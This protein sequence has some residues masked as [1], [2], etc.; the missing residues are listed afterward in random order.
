MEKDRIQT[1][2]DILSTYMDP[3]L[4]KLMLNDRARRDLCGVEHEAA[5]LFVDIRHF[6]TVCEKLSPTKVSQLLSLFQQYVM[7]MIHRYGGI[8]DKMMGDTTMAYWLN[9]KEEPEEDT[10]KDK[11]NQAIYDA[12]AEKA[13]KGALRAAH[14]IIREI[15]KLEKKAV[16]VCGYPL[17]VAIGIH[18]GP[19]YFGNIGSETRKD[20]TIVGNAVNIAAKLKEMAPAGKV[21]VS[22]AVMDR[23]SDEFTFATVLDSDEEWD[24]IFCR[25]GEMTIYELVQKAKELSV[26]QLTNQETE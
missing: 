23:V 7:D 18:Y 11:I 12:K 13:V 14:A 9:L 21:Y 19:V 24:A 22:E 25:E 15:D 10:L 16:S 26:T 6:N 17:E 4:V 2:G 3:Q 20:F 1:L 5:V 8:V